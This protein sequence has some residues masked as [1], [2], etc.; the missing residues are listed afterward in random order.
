MLTNSLLG[1]S[2]Q[3]IVEKIAPRTPLSG[4]KGAKGEIVVKEVDPPS[5]NL[6]KGKARV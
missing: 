2:Q 5:R 6:G 4:D 1:I 3:L